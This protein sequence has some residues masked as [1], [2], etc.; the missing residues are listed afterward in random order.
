MCSMMV[1]GFLSLLILHG[2]LLMRGEGVDY[3]GSCD[4]DADGDEDEECEDDQENIVL[5]IFPNLKVS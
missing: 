1:S 3:E 5:P 4:G 2:S